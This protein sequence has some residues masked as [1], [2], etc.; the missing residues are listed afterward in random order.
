MASKIGHETQPHFSPHQRIRNMSETA[1]PCDGRPEM[2]QLHPPPQTA[3]NVESLE[4]YQAMYNESITDP[5]GFWSRMGKELVTWHREF[6]TVSHGS[7]A[8]GDIAWYLGGEL[9]VSVNCL[10]RHLKTRGDKVALIWEGDEPGD[11]RKFTYRELHREVCKLASG[12]RDAGVKAGECVALYMPM[13]PEAI[14]AML[15]CARL[16]APHS[17]VFA[18]FSADALR[19]RILDAGCRVVMTADQGVRGGRRTNLKKTVDEALLEC[20]GVDLVIVHQRTGE[21]GPDVPFVAGRD[22]YMADLMAKARPYCVP[23]VRNAEDT[24]FVLYTS[25][26]TGRP[27][28]VLHT[29]AGYLVWAMMTHKYT[30]DLRDDDVFACMADIGWITGHTYNCYGPL[31][32]GATSMLFESTPLYPDAGR[33]WDV[34]ERHGVTQLYTAPTA[35]RALMK[36][37][38]EPVQKYDTSSLRVLGTVG[39]PIAPLAWNWYN[40]VVGAKQCTIVDTY[41]QTETGGHMLTALAGVTPTKPG[42]ATLPFFGVK[43]AIV[44]PDTGNVIEGNE[45]EGVLVMQQPWPGMCRTVLG[46]HQR[47]LNTYMTAYSGNY[48]TGDG[49]I[50]D[51]DGYYWITGR[52]DDVVNV[53]GHRLGT[54]EIEAAVVNHDAC[55]EAAAIGIPHELK[56]QDIFVYVILHNGYEPS[57]DLAHEL[58]DAV[59]EG[60]G[61]FAKPAASNIVFVEGL[62]KTRSGKLMRRILRL[63]ATG[64]ESRL[65]DVSTLADPAVVP[66]IIAAVKAKRDA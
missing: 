6:D 45:V 32:N 56:G 37:G 53:S 12:M 38:S 26:S 11:V 61:S 15:A 46:D 60:I 59:K 29:S 7:F 35:I 30:F 66:A 24:L 51:M 2:T 34:V 21:T 39:E 33:Y 62:P 19:D 22:V 47:Y 8:E 64:E 50:R 44:E 27:K 36:Y 1:S 40:E 28:G 23:A 14:F 5:D 42:S 65:G 18:G 52:V 57:D 49:A 3:A 63:I 9:N 31:A 43:P 25:G 48:F 13:V 54:A 17:V 16:G 10:D 4:A 41:W 20:P 58:R 55:V